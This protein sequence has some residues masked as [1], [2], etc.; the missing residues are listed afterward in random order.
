VSSGFSPELVAGLWRERR[1]SGPPIAHGFRS[2]YADRWVRF[3][4]LATA[5]LPADMSAPLPGRP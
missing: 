2:T 4:S 1:P 5:A 3:H